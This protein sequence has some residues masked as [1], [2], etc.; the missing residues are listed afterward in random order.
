MTSVLL[1]LLTS[2]VTWRVICPGG[3]PLCP[4]DSVS[5]CPWAGCS[6]CVCEAHLARVQSSPASRVIVGPDD[7]PIIEGGTWKPPLFS[8][9]VSLSLQPVSAGFTH[10]RA[11][12]LG[13]HTV[14]T[15]TFYVS[16]TALFSSPRGWVCWAASAC[17][18]GSKSGAA[19]QAQLFPVLGGGSPDI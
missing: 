9:A 13:A 18:S 2:F 15:V 7:L 16:Q 8:A 19:A 5:Y 14:V 12:R 17:V 10:S 3:C 6:A 11:L 1:D 4:W